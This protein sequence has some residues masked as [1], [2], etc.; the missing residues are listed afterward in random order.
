[1]ITVKFTYLTGLKRPVFTNGRLAGSWD[2][3]LEHTMQA[4][5]CDDGCPGFAATLPMDD[6]LAGQ[7]VRWGVRADG[8]QGA[9]LWAVNLEVPD[10][11]SSERYRELTLPGPGGAA[12][13][14]YHFTHSRYLG[15]QKY[16]RSP[17]APASIRFAVWAPNARRVDVVFGLPDSG[18]IWDDGSGIDHSRPEIALEPKTG[19]IWESP[20]FELFADF[21]GAPYMFRIVNAQGAT[22]YRTDI[23]SR[24]QVGRG[25]RDPNDGSW[26]GSPTTLDGGVSCSMVIDQ[27]LV[28]ENFL[29]A[30][31]DQH[32]TDEEFWAT[33]LTP[34]R[35][36]PGRVEDLIVY[37]LHVG[38][39]GFGRRDAGNL[40]DAMELIPYLSDLGVNAVEL[41]PMSESSGTLSWG[42]GD[43]HHFVIESS[44]GGRNSYKHFV[45][46]CHRHGIAVIQDVVYNHFDARAGRAEW[47]YDS[48]A[49]DE[50]IYY[51]Y[52]GRPEDY[53]HPNGGYLNNGSSGWTPRF[54]E[55]PVRQLFISSAA[56]FVE[57]FHVDGLRVDLTQAIHRDNSLMANGW[58]IGRANA[59]GQKFLR[60]W[61]RT[62]Q[63]IRPTVMLIAEDHTGWP[64]VTERADA[65][66]LGFDATWFA[67]YY[68]SLIGDADSA[69]GQARLL[70]EAGFGHGGPLRVQDFAGY[71]WESRGNRVVY[72]ESHDEAGNAEGS[73]RTI[74]VAVN[75]APLWGDTRKVAEARTRVVHGLTILSAG[76]PMFFMG[77]E[78]AAQRPCRYDNIADSKED[79]HGERNGEGGRMFRYFQDVIRLSRDS[80]AVRSHN[81]DIIHASDPNRVLAFTR[82][83]GTSEVLVVASLNNS[84]FENGYV[85]QT[86]GR[87]LVEGFWQEVFNSDSSLYGGNDKG[88]FSTAISVSHGRIQL[89]LPA[90]GLVVLHRVPG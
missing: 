25:D 18:Y 57:E 1:M 68:H 22:V 40:K 79:L 80:R 16:Y 27:D 71:L 89:R 29:L 59:F 61:S 13:A 28:R 72:S 38:S 26:D 69:G 42:Y 30:E 81:I 11:V 34:G 7:T 60:E 58:G 45:R 21:G 20:G 17:D 74:V 10:P 67:G 53:P 31:S 83:D 4:I 23:H 48:F 41:L 32:V 88:N 9:N 55:E 76:T 50:N 66:G 65:G 62:L 52:E 5:T 54:Y 14:R 56:E 37:E 47:E 70:K 33:E 73:A 6:S 82:S 35:P 75:G 12:E 39:L 24:W 43:T 44:A 63:A 77:E 46:E 15:A 49:P 51:W 3:W 8:P 84:A 2:G 85:I 19:G 86:E 36:L 90:N 78:I 87:R 64:A